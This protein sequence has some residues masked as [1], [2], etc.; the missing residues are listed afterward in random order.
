MNED[1]KLQVGQVE[2]FWDHVLIQRDKPQERRTPGGIVMPAQVAHHQAW[3]TVV[4]AGPAALE[5]LRVQDRVLVG[6]FVG[7]E[8]R[9]DDEPYAVVGL[10]DVLGRL[11][12]GQ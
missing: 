12:N 3:A 4:A 10:E 7:T 8:V 6:Q 2:M 9:I 11:T 5:V 1:A